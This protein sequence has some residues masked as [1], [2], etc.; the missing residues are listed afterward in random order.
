[1]TAQEI[2]IQMYH[3]QTH[4][5]GLQLYHEGKIITSTLL[6]NLKLCIHTYALSYFIQVRQKNRV[7]DVISETSRKTMNGGHVQKMDGWIPMCTTEGRCSPSEF[8]LTNTDLV[9]FPGKPQSMSYYFKFMQLIIVPIY[10]CIRVY[11]S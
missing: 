11:R 10:L 2:L 1:M 8:S 3:V 5:G 6:S 7:N 4:L 9:L